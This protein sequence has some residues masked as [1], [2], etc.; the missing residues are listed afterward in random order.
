MALHKKN[1]IVSMPEANTWTFMSFV[2]DRGR[3]VALEWDTAR[4]FA[5]EQ[6]FL[7][8]LKNNRNTKDYRK[9]PE[10]RHPMQGKAGAAGVV[11]LGFYE[12]SGKLQY[13]ILCKFNGAMC[14]IILCV[15]LH[16][17]NVWKPAHAIKT[18]TDRAKA[19]ASGKARLNVVKI[20]DSI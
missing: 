18:A 1:V 9:W 17:E 14:I 6:M 10:W 4:G 12:R 11:E 8:M 7:T 3:D 15:A 2:T 5:A 16:K 19:V 20:E 13:R